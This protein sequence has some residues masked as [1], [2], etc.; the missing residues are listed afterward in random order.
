MPTPHLLS[1]R[2]HFVRNFARDA[3]VTIS[4]KRGP[5]RAPTGDASEQGSAAEPDG[6]RVTAA[7]RRE[8]LGWRAGAPQARDG[9]RAGL[10]APAA[11]A[12]T[13]AAA[14]TAASSSSSPGDGGPILLQVAASRASGDG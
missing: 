13:P 3:A 10:T 9:G 4:G 7:R 6:P 11:A 8:A 2:L 12:G 5:A 1:L 14:A